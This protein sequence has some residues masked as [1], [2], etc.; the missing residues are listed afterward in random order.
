[1][2]QS[3][4]EQFREQLLKEKERLEGDLSES[5]VKT[6]GHWE[7]KRQQ[8]D[9]AGR[10]EEEERAD[11]VEEYENE[12]S[13]DRQ[14]ETQLADIAAALQKI[15]AGT[16]GVCEHCKKEIDETRL[17]ANPAARAHITCYLTTDT[18]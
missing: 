18:L 13:V 1:M 3:R 9:E 15:E 5:A 11:E 4:I 17:S 14:L 7:T 8:F 12:A 16:Y 10:F 6:D 2:E